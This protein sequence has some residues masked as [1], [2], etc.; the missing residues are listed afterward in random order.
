[1]GASDVPA[2]VELGVL[3]GDELT[4]KADVLELAER[5]ISFRFSDEVEEPQP[6]ITTPATEI[7]ETVRRALALIVL[8][9]GATDTTVLAPWASFTTLPSLPKQNLCTLC[10]RSAVTRV[11]RQASASIMEARMEVPV[12]RVRSREVTI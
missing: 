9:F 1:V 6:S 8:P 3:E 7:S 5:R 2:V 12:Q 10:P 11:I 4:V